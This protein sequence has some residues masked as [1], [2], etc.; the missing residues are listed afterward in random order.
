MTT[1]KKT[2]NAKDYPVWVSELKVS[3]KS[4]EDYL[5]SFANWCVK[6]AIK[7][8]VGDIDNLGDTSTLADPSVIEILVE[9]RQ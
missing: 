2:L 5:T 9:E 8:G 7:N 6:Y 3:K 1:K 4:P